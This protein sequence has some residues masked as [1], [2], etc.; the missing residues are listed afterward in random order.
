MNLINSV[1]L[2]LVLVFVQST[3]Q[4]SY[5]CDRNAPCG[6]SS[7]PP[8]FSRIVGGEGAGTGTW[9]WTVSISIDGM[10]LCGGSILS[11]SWILSAAHCFYQDENATIIIYAGSN[12]QWMGSQSRLV[13]QVIL[14][15]DYDESTYS[16]DIALL[17]LSTPLNMSDPHITPICMP[18]VSSTTLE[19]S[20]WPLVNTTVSFADIPCSSYWFST[21]CCR[22][23]G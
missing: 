17:K 7:N 16:N 14:H 22:W 19:P 4:V 11:Q 1:Y 18:F 6:C 20:E 9:D 2:I 10:Y 23:M 3:E 13:S 15:A 12:L 5:S 8:S 21:G